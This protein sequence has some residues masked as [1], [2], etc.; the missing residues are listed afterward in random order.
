[1]AAEGIDDFP[2]LVARSIDEPEWFWDAVVRSSACAFDDAVHRGARHVATASRGRSGSSAAAATSRRRASTVAPTIRR[3]ATAPRSSGKARRATVRTLTWAELRAL[4]DRIAPGSRRAACGAGDAVGLFLPMVPETVAALFAVAKLGAVFLPIFSGYGADAVAVRLDDARR[5]RARHRR[6]LHAA[7]QGRA[8][9]GDRRRRGRAA[10]TPCTRSSSCRGSGATDLPMTAGRDLTLADLV[11]DSARRASTPTPVDSEHPLFVAYTS[12]TTGRPKG[13]VHVHGGF[14][15]KIAEEVAFQID[16]R[17]GRAPVLAHRHRL[18][19]GAVGD[20]RH[21]RQRRHARAATTARPTFPGPT[22]SGRSSSGTASTSSASRRR[23][24]RAL[25]AHGDE[26][27]RAHDLS[28]LRVL[29]S[30]GEPW[31]EGPWRW[32]FDVVGGGRCPVINISGGTE[33]GACFLSPHVVQPISPCSLG[34]PALGMAVDVFDDDGQPVRGE[35]GELVCTKPWPGMTRGLCHDPRALPRDLLVALARTCGGTA[36][37][38]AS[39]D[40]RA[41]VPA[42]PLRRHDQARGQAARSGRGRDG[43]RRASRRCVEAA[44]VGVPD[45]LKGEALW[46]FVVLAPGRRR[47]RRAARRAR[48]SASPTRSGRRSSPPAGALHDARC[49]RRAAPRCCAARSARSSTGDAPG[50]LSGLEDPGDARRDR[51]ERVTMTRARR[52][53]GC[54]SGRCGPTTGTRGARCGCGAATG[55]SGGSRVPEAGQRRSRA[56]PRRVPCPV[57]RVGPAAPL[58]RRVRLRPVPR[59]RPLR[60][61]GQPRQRAA[62]P[63]PDGLR[64]LLDRRGARR[65]AATCPK[66]SC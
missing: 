10:S 51:G 50:D 48:R 28:S 63:V 60:G 23:S 8:D 11:R 59:R 49:R 20:R 43:R 6:R 53:R 56:R 22:G 26:P 30:T 13:A 5:G 14:L 41:V 18:D 47:R 57:R 12:G 55:S 19:H 29:A 7:R 38:R 36:T 44:A 42:R 64:R 17:A 61:R 46:V 24:I 33:V 9:E 40:R 3:R 4:T 35:V 32:Y 66:A 27:V 37:S 62:R 65:A 1:M 15:V 58:R 16:L 31:N 45:E 54:C 39:I 2:E 25:M 52:R 21:A 34:G